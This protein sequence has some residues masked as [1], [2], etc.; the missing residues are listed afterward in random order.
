MEVKNVV[1]VGGAVPIQVQLHDGNE[2]RQVVVFVL[3]P[4]GKLL[5]KLDLVSGTGGLYYTNFFKMPDV[6]FVVVQAHVLGPD[7]LGQPYGVE[8]ERFYSAP[9]AQAPEK[10]LKGTLIFSRDAEKIMKGVLCET[11]IGE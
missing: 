4:V 6:E 3:D 7:D 5:E 2:T 10:I 1:P 9:K 11:T 8:S